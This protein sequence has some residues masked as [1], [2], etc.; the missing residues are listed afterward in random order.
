MP[1]IP[2]YVKLEAQKELAR[3]DFYEYSKLKYP[4][5]YK[6]NRVFLKEMCNEMQ[7]FVEEPDDRFLVINVPPRHYKSFTGTG[8]VEWYF[9]KKPDKKV[10]SAGYNETLSTTFARK[11]RDTIEEK[12][13]GDVLVYSDIF[14]DV[15]V[16]RGQAS[17]SL[18]ALEGSSQDSYLA[19]SPTGTATGFGANIIL[20]DDIIKNDTEAYNEV[21]LDKLW[22]WWVNT[23]MQRTEGSD[24]KIIIIMTRWAK[25]D[26][27]GRIL[28]NYENVRHITYKAVQDD[29]SMLCD[30]ILTHKDYLIKTKE[31]SLDIAEA[32]YQQKPIDVKGRLYNEFA[33]WSERPK[34]SEG[35]E[36]EIK[37]LNITDTA[38]KGTD[39]L[40]SVNYFV[41]NDEAYITELVYNDESMEITEPLVVDLLYNGDVNS[42]IFESNNGGRGYARN[43]ERGLKDKYGT[44]KITIVAVAQ[45]QNKE[46]RILSSSAWVQ[47]HVYMPHNWQHKFKE[48][49]KEVTGYQRK[50][51]NA[52]DDGVDV[53][54]SI[55]EMVTGKIKLTVTNQ[56]AI[57]LSLSRN[58]KRR[59]RS[60]SLV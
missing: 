30:D 2:S 7:A 52:H 29:G 58:K 59:R 16:K 9:G 55:Y 21:H 41:H 22:S 28:G 17:A 14:P 48:F 32:N 23:M 6:K 44:N 26:L 13:S 47:I 4:Q 18:W 10:L 49:Y 19:S 53:L 8:F 20:V 36:I 43:I 40:C 45:T 31:M 38:D 24:W 39:N 5:H 25:G 60:N 1:E 57:G 42:A 33:T 3:R 27:A 11:V 56:T 37:T 54:A 46:A 50:G 35:N 12:K 34:D 51:K 15:R